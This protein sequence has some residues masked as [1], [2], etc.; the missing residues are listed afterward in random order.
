MSE[1]YDR[2]TDY[3][4]ALKEKGKQLRKNMTRQERHLWYD[5]LKNYPVKWYRQR[6]I[7]QY[8][9]DFY[10]SKAKLVL[11]LDGSQHYTVDGEEYDTVRTEILEAY[12]LEVLRIPN[13]EIDRNFSGACRMIE[14]KTEER[15]KSLP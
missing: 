12:Q 6:P 14:W 2:Y 11:E 13:I 15:L 7:N 3:N 10:C 8:I 9:V 1:L 4:P 5:F